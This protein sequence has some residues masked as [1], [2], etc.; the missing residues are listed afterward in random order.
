MS[1]I[2]IIH[3]DLQLCAHYRKCLNSRY[4]EKNVKIIQTNLQVENDSNVKFPTS[5]Y[6]KQHLLHGTHI[7][8]TETLWY[9]GKNIRVRVFSSN[10]GSDFISL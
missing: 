7:F 6:E 10:S 1:T 2:I 3:S 9:T 8:R 4:L 5:M